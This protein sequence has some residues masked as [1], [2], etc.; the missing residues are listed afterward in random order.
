MILIVILFLI[1]KKPEE[2]LDIKNSETPIICV[3]KPS[4]ISSNNK[5]KVYNFNTNWCGYSKQFQHIWDEFKKDNTDPDIDI[6]DVKCDD[7]NNLELCKKYNIPGYPTVLFVKDDKML[8][9]KGDRTV[10]DL[11]K[12]CINFKK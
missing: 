10:D 8:E 11:K 2:F 3:S 12:E 6:I 5:I 7:E 4:I 9:Y 1:L